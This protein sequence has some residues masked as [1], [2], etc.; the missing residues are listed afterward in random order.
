MKRILI[1]G[2]DSY[3][4]SS[5]ER[6][7]KQWPDQ[8]IVDTVDLIDSTWR[9]KSF[10]EYDV[11]F[12]VAGIAHIKETKKNEQLY[13]KINRDLAVE[14]AKKAKNNGAEQFIFMSTMSIYG[15]ETGIITQNTLPNPKNNYGKSKLQAEKLIESLCNDVFKVAILRPPM[16]YGKGC[17]GNYARLANLSIRTPIFPDIKNNRSMIYI[18]N[19][20]EYI[21][22]VI[23]KD[24]GGIFFPQDHEY[25]CTTDMVRMIAEIHGKKIFFTKFFNPL[26][27]FIKLNTFNKLFGDLTYSKELLNMD[28]DKYSFIS[29]KQS[30]RF[31]E[32]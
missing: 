13:Y 4:G 29:L 21:R 25:I 14:V 32:E 11:I 16:V 17:K 1:T 20:C 27:K 12:H 24:I 23:D 30:I 8:Y 6:Y 19:L 10:A 31:T 26:F 2:A 9:K 15:Q 5:F 22:R 7:M 3:I 28:L 18:D